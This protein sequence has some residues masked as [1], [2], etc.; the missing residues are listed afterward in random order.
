MLNIL[1]SQ[2]VGLLVGFAAI[3]IPAASAWADPDPCME[4]CGFHL[5]QCVCGC[6][7]PS[8]G[9]AAAFI[10]CQQ[11]TFTIQCRCVNALTQY[12]CIDPA[13]SDVEAQGTRCFYAAIACPIGYGPDCGDVPLFCPNGTYLSDECGPYC[14]PSCSGE[15]VRGN[16]I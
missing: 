2:L 1:R 13:F 9:C 5:F 10:G 15:T 6:N 4:C 16:P 12:G 8:G 14:N 11:V 7:S 3:V